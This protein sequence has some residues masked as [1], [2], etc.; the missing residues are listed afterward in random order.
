MTSRAREEA[1]PVGQLAPVVATVG[2]F[3]GLHLGHWSVIGA[4]ADRAEATG[5]RSVLVT[6]EPHP[7]AVVRPEAA[8]RRLTTAAE[9]MELLERSRLDDVVV[10]AFT[11]E[12]RA[13][14]PRRFVTELLL[15]RLGVDELVVGH[16]HGFGRGRA[17]DADTLARLGAELG[18][19]VT[20]RGPVREGTDVVSSS[21]IRRALA[22]GDLARANRALGRPYS[23]SGTVV[24]GDGRGRALGVP[25]ANIMISDPDKLVPAEG[26]YAC[27]ASVASGDF[28][29]ALH[30]GPR[31]T[32]PRAGAAIEVHLLDFEGDLYG[33]ALRLRLVE[34][35]RAVEA[36]ET[37]G[38]LVER[39]REDI[40]R[41]REVLGRTDLL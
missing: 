13:H 11:P 17:G 38:A 23:I 22:G 34:R 1:A 10:L 29:G 33:S 9:R 26:V 21:R 37:A 7:L 30:I 31:P 4:V 39:M 14:S 15:G 35:L 16:D 8:P 5:G 25:T 32:F 41:S 6:F 19:S 18:F 2:T 24:R 36:F 28:A 3:D 12:L 20:V 27:R 40:E